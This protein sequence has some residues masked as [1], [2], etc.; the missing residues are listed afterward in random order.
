MYSAPDAA[1]AD[2]GSSDAA[3]DADTPAGAHAAVAPAAADSGGAVLLLLGQWLPCLHR[4][5][6][7]RLRAA[8]PVQRYL[9]QLAPIADDDCTP[10]DS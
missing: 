1:A 5:R 4:G 6:Q 9:P 10:Q 3:S 8:G 7:E 2:S